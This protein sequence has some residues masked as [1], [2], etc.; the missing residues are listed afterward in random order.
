MHDCTIRKAYWIFLILPV[1][2]FELIVFTHLWLIHSA[3]NKLHT[4]Y[5]FKHLHS[6]IDTL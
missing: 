4:S 6:V 3:L 2:T 5:F 1:I